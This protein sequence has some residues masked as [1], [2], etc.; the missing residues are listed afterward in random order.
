[1]VSTYDFLGLLHTSLE[2]GDIPLRLI[3]RQLVDFIFSN[4][5]QWL[6]CVEFPLT[7]MPCIGSASGGHWVWSREAKRK[8]NFRR[9]EADFGK[10]AGCAG[11]NQAGWPRRRR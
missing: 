2:L 4:Y 5:A 1:M 7:Y 9:G 10:L 3:F 6:L 11:A 8:P